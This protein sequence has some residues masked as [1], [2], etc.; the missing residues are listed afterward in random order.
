MFPFSTTIPQVLNPRVARLNATLQ[1]LK[2]QPT[3]PKAPAATASGATAHAGRPPQPPQPP[4]PDKALVEILLDVRRLAVVVEHQPLEASL[5]LHGSLLQVGLEPW[6]AGAGHVGW[7]R[8]R[9]GT[10]ST[11]DG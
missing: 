1:L 10:R 3:A 4:L 6:A 8:P 9:V 2:K 11:A 7:H 5:A